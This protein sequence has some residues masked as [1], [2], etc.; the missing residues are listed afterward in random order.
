MNGCV[1]QHT[2]AEWLAGWAIS[3]WGGQMDGEVS[4]CLSYSLLVMLCFQLRAAEVEIKDLQSEFELEKID[5]LATIRRQE[6][7]FMLFQQLLEQVQPL[8][9]RDCNYSNLEK[10]RR[11]CCWDEDNGFWKIPEPVII[12]TSLPVGQEPG[13]PLCPPCLPP[14]FAVLQTDREPWASPCW[15]WVQQ[16]CDPEIP[17]HW[18][19]KEW[20]VLGSDRCGL[21]FWLHHSLCD[22]LGPSVLICEMGINNRTFLKDCWVA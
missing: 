3:G 9:R 18:D 21:E 16:T 2:D 19:L 13:Y 12:K 22:L 20:C 4:W 11:E 6:R 1:D 15:L 8:V 7:D 17:K 14:E 5:Y 10:I